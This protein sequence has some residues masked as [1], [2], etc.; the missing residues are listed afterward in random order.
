[1]VHHKRIKGWEPHPSHF[2]GFDFVDVWL[3]Q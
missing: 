3:D 2:T 1:V